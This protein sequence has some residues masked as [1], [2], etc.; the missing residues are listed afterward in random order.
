M[1][2]YS[3]GWNFRDSRIYGYEKKESNCIK[4]IKTLTQNNSRGA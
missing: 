1:G 3:N 2:T 4:S